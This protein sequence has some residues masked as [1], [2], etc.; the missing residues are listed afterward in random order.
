MVS[1]WVLKILS[2]VA[3]F[4]TAT[5][6]IGSLIKPVK[7]TVSINHIDKF[8]HLGAYLGLAFLWLSLYHLIKQ[9]KL[10]GWQPFRSYIFIAILLVF[11]GIMIEV[12]QGG[13]T[14]YRTP[15]LWD[16]LANF[17]G[18]VLGGST[19]ILFFKTFKRLKTIN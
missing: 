13:V 6:T 5:L 4:Y 9:R 16:V 11:Y 10:K 1:S 15:D 8:L 18:V 3:V 14:D 7:I 2:V 19:F 12:L 17:I